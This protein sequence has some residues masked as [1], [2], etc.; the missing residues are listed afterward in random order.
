MTE[1]ITTIVLIDYYKD[2]DATRSSG[3]FEI[4]NLDDFKNIFSNEV[5]VMDLKCYNNSYNYDHNNK[6]YK[7]DINGFYLNKK[8]ICDALIYLGQNTKEY[9]DCLEL[10]KNSFNYIKV[11]R[12]CAKLNN[13][14]SLE[15]QVNRGLSERAKELGMDIEFNIANDETDLTKKKLFQ[16]IYKEIEK[17]C[18]SEAISMLTDFEKKGDMIKKDTFFGMLLTLTKKKRD[19]ELQRKAQ[20]EL[21]KI[22]NNICSIF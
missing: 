16:I 1:I 8:S 11:G 10:F 20:A 17:Y 5:E 12:S 21:E 4:R 2:I 22:Q 18:G 7:P 13:L 6:L 3:K 15:E 9:I 14:I 19:L